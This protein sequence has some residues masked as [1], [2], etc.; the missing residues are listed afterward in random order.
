M[1]NSKHDPLIRVEEEISTLTDLI[2]KETAL[3]KNQ[4]NF[5]TQYSTDHEPYGFEFEDPIDKKIYDEFDDDILKVANEIRI[6]EVRINAVSIIE[7]LKA[8]QTVKD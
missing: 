4:Q 5:S 6:Q 2:N 3:I 1:K 8:T 7:G